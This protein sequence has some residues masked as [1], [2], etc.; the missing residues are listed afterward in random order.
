MYE[1]YSEAFKKMPN[2]GEMLNTFSKD[3]RI[4]QAAW[5]RH[6]GI[7]PHMIN[8]LFK[9]ATMQISTLYLVSLI[10]KNNFIREIA[11]TLPAELPARS[12]TALH[13]QVENLKKEI[14]RLKLENDLLKGIIEKAVANKS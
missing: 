4:H 8:R 14:E 13:T 6:Q 11:D 10:L 12:E 7:K 9:K 5:A 3:K 2:V 1:Q